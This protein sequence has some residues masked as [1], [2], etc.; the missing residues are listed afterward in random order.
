MQSC[1]E[2]CRDTAGTPDLDLDLDLDLDTGAPIL[3]HTLVT[4]PGVTSSLSKGQVRGGGC[5]V[6]STVV[7]TVYS[8]QYRHTGGPGEGGSREGPV[9]EGTPALQHA[10]PGTS[11]TCSVT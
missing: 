8:V 10:R 1:A 9:C 3:F 11:V 7:C 2:L 4:S 6:Y 5:T